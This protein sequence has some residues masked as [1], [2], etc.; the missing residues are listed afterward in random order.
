M[1]YAM[2]G[3]LAWWAEMAEVAV[4]SALTALP[5]CDIPMASTTPTTTDQQRHAFST[6]LWVK[7][8]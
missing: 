2:A 8:G 7:V 3:S 5:P 1:A 6:P 4:H